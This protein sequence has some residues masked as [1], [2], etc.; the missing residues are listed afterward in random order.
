[1]C[2]SV[3]RRLRSV[4]SGP[5]PRAC[6][7]P[8][9]SPPPGS[10]RRGCS[11]SCSPGRVRTWHL[12]WRTRARTPLTCRSAR[13][14]CARGLGPRPH[15]WA[16]VT[17]R[18]PARRGAQRPPAS[19]RCCRPKSK[20]FGRCVCDFISLKSA[21]IARICANMLRPPKFRKTFLEILARAKLQ[22]LQMLQMLHV[23]GRGGPHF[24]FFFFW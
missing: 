3:S 8:R 18:S 6:D 13:R 19:A 5:A 24:F 15:H 14:R 11:P 22:M 17:P 23:A 4:A 10:G 1:M 12:P 21:Q 7:A 2:V 16:V 9:A 20:Y